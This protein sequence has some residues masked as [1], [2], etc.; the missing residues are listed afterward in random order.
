VLGAEGFSNAYNTS[1][2]ENNYELKGYSVKH[3]KG[4]H[5]LTICNRFT[6]LDAKVQS[7]PWSDKGWTTPLETHELDSICKY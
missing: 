1:I 7:H 2:N 6:I 3:G 4:T 5:F